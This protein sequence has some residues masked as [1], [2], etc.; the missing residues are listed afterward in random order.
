[1]DAL[2][3]VDGKWNPGEHCVSYHNSNLAESSIQ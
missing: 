2:V 3:W 1:M